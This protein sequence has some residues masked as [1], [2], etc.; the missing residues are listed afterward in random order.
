[1]LA[2]HDRWTTTLLD[3]T[4]VVHAIVNRGQTRKSVFAKH[5][6]SQGRAGKQEETASASRYDVARVAR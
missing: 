2:A 3:A 5:A 1:M 4:L 6:L